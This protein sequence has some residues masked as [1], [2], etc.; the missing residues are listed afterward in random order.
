MNYK[1]RIKT[2]MTVVLCLLVILSFTGCGSS[3]S[4]TSGDPA[5][6]ASDLSNTLVYAGENTD[7]INPVITGQSE[8]VSIIFS[9]LM[10]YDVSGHPV[11]DLVKS[12]TYDEN[13]LTYTFNLRQGVLW[14]DGQPFT[15][16][17]VVYT[18]QELTSD[19]T[20]ASSILDDYKD[21]TNVKAT[22]ENTV[23]ITLSQYDAAMLN[24]FT[25]GILPKHLL[26][27]QDLTTSPFNQN[28][29]GTG[30]YKFVQWDKAGGTV[31]LVRNEKYYD[32]I[33]NIEK[34]VYKT[35]A[36]ESTKALMLQSGEADLAW[37]NAK[38]AKDFRGK[39]GFTNYDFKTAD[40]RAMS[41]DFR[42]AFWTQNKD[43]IGVL[44][45]AIDKEAVVNSVLTGQGCTAYSTMQLNAFGGNKDADIYPYD[46]S[47]FAAEM[48]KLGWTKGRDGIYERNGQ[49][50]HF[51]IQ[52]RDYE[53]ERV[54]IANVV[55]K[56]LKDAGVEMEIVL[57]TKFDWNS[58]YDGFLA[59][60]AVEFDPDAAY[61]QFITNGSSNTMKYSNPAVDNILTQARHAQ[62]AKE[63][64]RLYGEF[65]VAFAK[66][67]ASVLIAY[68]DGNYVGI[69]GLEGPDTKRVLGHHAVGVM[70]NIEDW[71]LTK[72]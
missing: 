1:E 52:V 27:G 8:L 19:K 25:I 58:G 40:Y 59:G 31:T 15:A 6:N 14:Q 51:K 68:L 34:I 39:E 17:D 54:D 37:L 45:Y 70:W 62:D 33:P 28:P 12:Y 67:P 5:K 38:Y 71:K 50:F 42:S 4:S 60:Y 57:V 48:A 11:V 43:S 21:I 24:Y 7:T 66:E 63:R 55:Y 49:K 41:M 53:E 61:K 9:G 22:D 35:V 72:K 20:L 13:S 18:Y 44:N 69:S 26:E 64:K 23:E 65:E 30:R 10:K 3:P 16:E 2:L 56:Q 47:K 36:V 32:K 29:V 46:L